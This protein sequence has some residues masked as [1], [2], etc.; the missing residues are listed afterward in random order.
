MGRTWQRKIDC[1]LIRIVS[2]CLAFRTIY[3]ISD[4]LHSHEF[5]HII[6]IFN[7]CCKQIDYFQYNLVNLVS[8]NCGHVFN[9]KCSRAERNMSKTELNIQADTDVSRLRR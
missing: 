4:L 8:I 1:F 7:S 3:H 2:M 9:G 6:N 5:T